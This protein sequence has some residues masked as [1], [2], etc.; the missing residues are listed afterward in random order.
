M[1]S[2]NSLAA[3]AFAAVLPATMSTAHAAVSADDACSLLTRV[4]VSAVVNRPV[5]A[6]AYQGT[7]KK[8]CTWNVL[9]AQPNSA[10][11]VTV[12]FE[13]LGVFQANK[14]AP[15]K[16]IM[17]TPVRR[18]GDDAYYIAVRNNVGLI[19]KKGNAVFK[20]AVYGDAPIDKMRAME[21]S[22]AQ[23]IAAEL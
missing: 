7:F 6:G 14:V 22:F 5:A 16:A 1:S 19:V 15:V 3:I 23:R 13:D 12:V 11:S 8:T 21:R 18:V 4:Q 2:K 10:K 20:V 9:E 17:I